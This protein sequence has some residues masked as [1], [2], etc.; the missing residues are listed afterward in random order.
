MIKHLPNIL[1][2][3]NLFSGGCAIV[4]I[5][6]GQPM[7]A[8]GCTVVSLIADFFDGFAARKLGVA[9]E[10]GVQLDSLAD[11]VSFGVV[12][13]MMI[14]KMLASNDDA[15]FF[16]PALPAL[17]IAVFSGYRLAL[18]NIDTRQTT[19]FIGLNTPTN[20]IFWVGLWLVF[21]E[22]AFGL[23]EMVSNPMFL[24]A[25]IAIF[26]YLL[27]AEIPMFSFKKGFKDKIL[28]VFLILSL[29]LLAIFKA[30]GISLAVLLYIALNIG[31]FFTKN[32]AKNGSSSLRGD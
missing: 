9:G 1:T 2:L 26:S 24:Y 18:F 31:V 3:T 6:S 8:V 4:C 27:I 22:N 12:P 15:D 7:L 23:R 19:G 11:M 32:D 16:I 20:T 17:L 29:I 25:A 28:L 30:L 10:L 21:Q 14:Y 5:F 13:S